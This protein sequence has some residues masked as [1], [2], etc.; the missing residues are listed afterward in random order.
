MLK[1]SRNRLNKALRGIPRFHT[2]FI[3]FQ[4]IATA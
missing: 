1:I 4:T 3:L 2:E